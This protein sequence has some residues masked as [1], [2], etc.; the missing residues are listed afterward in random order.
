MPTHSSSSEAPDSSGWSAS[1]YNQ[2]ASFVYSP[3]YTSPVLDLL[4]A[5]S[6]EFIIDFGCGSGEVTMQIAET[7]GTHGLVVGVDQSASMVSANWYP[8]LDTLNTRKIDTAKK[9]GLN[10]AF[11]SDVQQLVYPEAMP[12]LR[13]IKF[14]AVFSNASLHWCKKDPKGV[15][16]SAKRVLR[17]GGRFVG[18]MGGFLNCIGVYDRAVILR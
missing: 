5:R 8:S 9:N 13:D 10:H 16:A 7:V 2:V 12:W 1:L 15:L 17:P 3:S 11:I 14:D 18:E 4:A 6:S